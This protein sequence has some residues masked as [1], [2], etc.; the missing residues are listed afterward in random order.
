MYLGAPCAVRSVRGPIDVKLLVVARTCPPL[1][2]IVLTFTVS[3]WQGEES[4]YCAEP[5]SQYT[6]PVIVPAAT[7]IFVCAAAALPY[8]ELALRGVACTLDADG[9]VTVGG[10]CC[11]FAATQAASTANIAI[12]QTSST[13][14]IRGSLFVLFISYSSS[15]AYALLSLRLRAPDARKPFHRRA[16][17][18]LLAT[19]SRLPVPEIT[20][21]PRPVKGNA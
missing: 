16:K 1:L 4:L 3:P 10:C 5:M 13:L 11:A 8:G 20:R 17:Q 6:K 19:A 2:L 14:S 9:R 15:R 7:F 21:R 18:I 12:T